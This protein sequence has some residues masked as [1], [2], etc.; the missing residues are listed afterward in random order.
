MLCCVLRTVHHRGPFRST[1][2]SQFESTRCLLSFSQPFSSTGVRFD[3]LIPFSFAVRVHLDPSAVAASS[4]FAQRLPS[5]CLFSA[6]TLLPFLAR[7]SSSES[8]YPAPSE[9]LWSFPSCLYLNALFL[10]SQLT[11]RQFLVCGAH[12]TGFAFFPDP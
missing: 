9:H 7:S 4:S 1:M 10:L 12:F 3:C 11:F 5:S 2:T 8:R 6:V